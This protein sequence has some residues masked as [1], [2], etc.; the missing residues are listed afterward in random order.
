MT[1]LRHNAVRSVDEL[2]AVVRRL[3]RAQGLTQIE[4]GELALVGARFVGELER[5]KASVQFDKV[6]LVLTALGVDVLV[7]Y[8][9]P[10]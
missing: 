10:A 8:P 3:R 6:L 9:E 7:E 5:G 1:V 2:G 4:L